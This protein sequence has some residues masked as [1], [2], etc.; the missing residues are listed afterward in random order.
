M[1]LHIFTTSSSLA[2]FFSTLS[3]IIPF[4][5]LLLPDNLRMNEASSTLTEVENT[6]Q[7]VC[8]EREIIEHHP[9]KFPLFGVPVL[10][11]CFF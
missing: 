8:A 7:E 1:A 10:V 2:F 3:P 5:L 11:L 6:L 9:F 4:P